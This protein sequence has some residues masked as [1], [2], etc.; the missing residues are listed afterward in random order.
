[1][2]SRELIEFKKELDKYKTKLKRQQIKTL[3]GQAKAGDLTGARK[4]LFNLAGGRNDNN[5]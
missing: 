2:N 3:M 1:M 5:N 4:G